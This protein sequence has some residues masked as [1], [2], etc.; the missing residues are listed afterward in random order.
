MMPMSP[1]VAN[2]IFSVQKC[3]IAEDV[4][5]DLQKNAWKTILEILGIPDTNI[6]RKTQ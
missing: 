3:V 1:L 4:Q 2:R 5:N 6:G